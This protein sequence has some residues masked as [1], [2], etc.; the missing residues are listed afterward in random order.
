M[1]NIFTMI[2]MRT[3]MNNAKRWTNLS[4]GFDVNPI[5]KDAVYSHDSNLST[6]GVRIVSSI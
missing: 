5:A 4:S 1:Y 6:E 3:Q 2:N